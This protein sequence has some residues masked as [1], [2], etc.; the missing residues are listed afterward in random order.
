MPGVR[1]GG[2][3]RARRAPVGRR[4]WGSRARLSMCAKIRVRCTLCAVPWNPRLSAH[5]LGEVK[6]RH[7]VGTWPNDTARRVWYGMGSTP[8]IGGRKGELAYGLMVATKPSEQTTPPCSNPRGRACGKKVC[9]D[10]LLETVCRRGIEPRRFM[11]ASSMV[12]PP[13][14]QDK[15]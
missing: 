2:R 3:R 7:V 5:S 10:T 1:T 12:A 15:Y 11:I 8:S 13:L 4:A 6:E 9:G 14:T